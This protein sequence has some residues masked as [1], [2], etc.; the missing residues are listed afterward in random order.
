MA[1]DFLQKA[2]SFEQK[3]EID[4][5]NKYLT[6]YPEIKNTYNLNLSSDFKAHSTD[7]V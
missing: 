3:K 7:E 4:F 6:M 1:L 5:F 2:A